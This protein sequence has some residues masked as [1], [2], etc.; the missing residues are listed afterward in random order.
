MGVV[1][2][3]V[4]LVFSG[5]AELVEDRVEAG[6]EAVVEGVEPGEGRGGVL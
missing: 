5:L 3:V 1:A 2:G 4:L 6:L